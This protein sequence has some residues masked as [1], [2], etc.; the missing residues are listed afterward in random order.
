MSTVVTIIPSILLLGLT[1]F[2]GFKYYKSY[3]TMATGDASGLLMMV[4][5]ILQVIL[6]ITMYATVITNFYTLYTTYGTNTSWIAFGTT[7]TIIPT[8]LFLAGLF[9]GGLLAW[10]GGQKRKSK[11]AAAA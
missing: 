4:I 11:A 7:I 8:V 9:S 1:A 5:G 3:Q 2:F 10:K 6:F